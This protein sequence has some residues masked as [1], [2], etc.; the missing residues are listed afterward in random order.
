MCQIICQMCQVCAKTQDLCHLCSNTFLHRSCFGI[1]FFFN[2]SQTLC[3]VTRKQTALRQ[4]Q[5]MQCSL[6]KWR[7]PDQKQWSDNIYFR[8]KCTKLL[9]VSCWQS[10]KL[11]EMWMFIDRSI[12]SL[13][14]LFMKLGE[15]WNTVYRSIRR[16]FI[17]PFYNV[18]QTESMC[19]LIL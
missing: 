8:I 9:V 19:H 1:S 3:F 15:M 6:P 12:D 5:R 17:L 18:S 16:F 14:F 7:I 4:R 11:G 13:S 2:Q 10:M